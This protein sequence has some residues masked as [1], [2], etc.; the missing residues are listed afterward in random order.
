MSKV[1]TAL[2]RMEETGVITK[3]SEPTEW[4]AGMVVV[5]KANGNVRICVDLPPVYTMSPAATAVTFQATVDETWWPWDNEGNG[6]DK[7]ISPRLPWTPGQIFKQ[8][9]NL[10]PQPRRRWPTFKNVVKRD[11]RN[12]TWQYVTDRNKT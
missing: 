11:E 12:E 2:D 8:S 6:I 1:K 5:P 9:K 7:R 4:C 3:I 10:P